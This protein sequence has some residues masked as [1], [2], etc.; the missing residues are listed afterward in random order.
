M[1]KTSR[2]KKPTRKYKPRNEFRRNNSRTAKSHYNFVFGETETHYKSLGLTKHPREDI[3]H[4][5]LTKN[6][7]PNDTDKSYLQ[8]KVLSTH[9]KYMPKKEEGWGF[10]KEDM[11]VVRHTIKRYK[12]ST[13]RKPKDWYVKKRKWRN[14]NRRTS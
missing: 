12:K 14:K 9:K 10:A 3:P 6:P 2:K 7:N 11:S 4:Y 1:I 8:L 5:L 13:N